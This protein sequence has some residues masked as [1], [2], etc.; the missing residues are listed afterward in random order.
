M[1]ALLR[2]RERGSARRGRDL[3][4]GGRGSGP[5]TCAGPRPRT[6][7]RPPGRRGRG[8]SPTLCRR[9]P[10]SARV[11]VVGHGAGKRDRHLAHQLHP[12]PQLE[13]VV[14]A[15]VW[16]SRRTT[17]ASGIVEPVEQPQQGRL[18][19]TRRTDDGG[20]AARLDDGVGEFEDGTVVA[21]DA[22]VAQLEAG[23][24]RHRRHS[25]VRLRGARA[26][27]GGFGGFV[28]RPARRCGRTVGSAGRGAA[29]LG[30]QGG[31]C[32]ERGQGRLPGHRRPVGAR[33]VQG[34]AGAAVRRAAL[35]C[36][37]RSTS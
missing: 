16:P 37:W 29:G 33:C 28:G 8:T 9:G 27:D 3:R 22:H 36:R 25:R 4:A 14:L 24:V 23:V 26:S 19:R 34:G 21:V 12:P 32:S 7:G 30:R 1:P 13:H 11:E 15:H 18:A 35:A 5:G 2:C 10:G 17:P 31:S 20:Q 6:A